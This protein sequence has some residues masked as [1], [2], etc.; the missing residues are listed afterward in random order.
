M[1]RAGSERRNSAVQSQGEVDA[2]NIGSQGKPD[3]LA[4]DCGCCDADAV[5]RD[6][7]S[8]R[9]DDP[10]QSDGVACGEGRKWRCDPGSPRRR[11]RW[12]WWW[13]SSRRRAR[14]GGRARGRGAW[15][16]RSWRRLPRGR[17]LPRWRRAY[18][19]LPRRWFPRGWLP[20]RARLSW[21]RLSLRRSSPLRRRRIPSL[22]HLSPRLLRPSP[23]PPALLWRLL[24]LLQPSA[25]LPGHLDLL[26]PAPRLPLA[27]LAPSVP[28]LVM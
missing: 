1:T 8:C 12:T 23:F 13:R 5:G 9:G 27:S 2:E 22:R 17:R 25:P 20:R 10:D 7:A 19:W 28:L 24:S 18:R 15:G 11:R 14:W 26:R 4:R 6:H 16:W 3:A 21:R